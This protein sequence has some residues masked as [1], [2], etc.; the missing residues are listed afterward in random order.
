M[1]KERVVLIGRT[2]R[3]LVVLVVHVERRGTIR[4]ISARQATRSER[5][6]Y[7]EGQA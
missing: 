3:D 2:W 7:E 6:I 4:I 5:L 1:H